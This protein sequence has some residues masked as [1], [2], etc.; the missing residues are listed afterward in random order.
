MECVKRR[1]PALAVLA[2]L[3]GVPWSGAAAAGKIVYW[4]QAG[5]NE[6]WIKRMAVLSSQNV[7]AAWEWVKFIAFNEQNLTEVSREQDYNR[8]PALISVAKTYFSERM[9]V[10]PSYL[11]LFEE[12][13][14]PQSYPRPDHPEYT[15][16][17]R[18]IE[19]F[20]GRALK[21]GEISVLQAVTQAEGQIE[22]ILAKYL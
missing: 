2:C 3:V 22:P 19:S 15:Q 4:H 11:R 8:I 5:Q 7:A 14:H 16:I 9:K 21:T 18:T 13:T 1:A 6:A 17:G 20:V 12:T 10:N